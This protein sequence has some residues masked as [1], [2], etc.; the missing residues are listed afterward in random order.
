MVEDFSFQFNPFY[1]YAQD[2]YFPNP[3]CACVRAY[4]IS[5]N[6]QIKISQQKK[7][8]KKYTVKI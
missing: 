5:Q 2:L 8:S 7:L 1:P 4:R 3:M 6:S